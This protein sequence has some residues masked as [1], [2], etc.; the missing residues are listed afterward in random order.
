MNHRTRLLLATFLLLPGL[1]I[2]AQIP[3]IPGTEPQ[4]PAAGKSK[5]APAR[6]SLPRPVNPP[7]FVRPNAS[8]PPT[9]PNA[10]PPGFP[11]QNQPGAPPPPLPGANNGP[12]PAAGGPGAAAAKPPVTAGVPTP[13]KSESKDENYV[14]FDAASIEEV[15]DEYFRITKRRVLKDRGME[16]STVTIMAP[17]VFT[18]TEYQEVIEIGLLMHGFALV[19]AGPT[20][21]KLVATETG[22]SAQQQNVPMILKEDDLPKSDAVVSHVVQLNY[23]S[24]EEAANTLQSAIPP[25]PYGKIIAVPNA[26]TLVITEAS[27]TI[28]A[29]LELIKQIDLRPNTTEQKTIKLE[30]TDPEDVAKMLESLLDLKNQGSGT[31]GGSRPATPAQPAI[32]RAPAMPGVGGQPAGAQPAAAAAPVVTA[33][34]GGRTAEGPQPIIL[35]IVRTSSLLV[36]AQRSD[37]ERIEKLVAEIDAEA[38][39]TEFI[40]RKLNYIDLKTFL[41]LAEKAI[42][43]YDKNAS[44]STATS[45]TN[46]SNN[47]SN[48]NNT[49]FSNFNSGGGFGNN[50]LNSG[51]GGGFGGIGGGGGFGGG[52]GGLSG[53]GFKGQISTTAESFVVGRTLV[54][55]DPGSSKFLAAGP[56]EQLRMLEQLATEL[57][58]RPR[59]ILLSAVIGEFSLTDDFKFGLDWLNSLQNIAGDGNR[60]AGG[61]IN[62]QGTF[63]DPAKLA[64]PAGFVGSTAATAGGLTAY[65]HVARNLHVFMNTVEGTGRFKALQKPVLTT[66]NHQKAQIYIGEQIPIAGNSFTNGGVG[67]FTTSTQFIPVRIQLDITPHIFNDREVMLEFNQQNN[68]QGDKVTVSAGVTVP[69]IREQGMSN[70]LIVPDRTVAM[71]GG[72]ISESDRNNTSGV[73]FVVRLPLIKYLFGKKDTTKIRKE[74]MIFVQPAILPDGATQ[75]DEQQRMLSNSPVSEDV[76]RLSN[77]PMTPETPQ[78]PQQN[79]QQPGQNVQPQPNAPAGQG[80]QDARFWNPR[81]WKFHRQQKP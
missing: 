68:S 13:P 70:S 7:G 73:P 60:F 8:V 37:M 76:L 35:P 28:R 71:L 5:A 52:G 31:A 47:S 14:A 57:D 30:R 39:G 21:Y 24:A 78:P 11:G 69:G 51:F 72:L 50:G 75:M 16:S 29:Y 74:I 17:G 49:G 81:T 53:G 41:G 6:P 12:M 23:I 65:G 67:G 42:M 27:Q 77:Q 1:A 79:P 22:S 34:G 40:S 80:T 33:T 3:G 4:A 59:Q 10:V 45:T 44:G 61:G 20:L 18:D 2:H 15:L 48:T 63:F 38:D 54:I 19:Q 25:H 58:V 56:P 66:L 55:I 26:R 32:P 46:N 43:R 36:T 9:N 64:T 62:T